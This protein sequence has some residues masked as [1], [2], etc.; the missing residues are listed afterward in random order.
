MN[1]YLEVYNIVLQY[2]ME[3]IH[4]GYTKIPLPQTTDEFKEQQWLYVAQQLQKNNSKEII[5]IAAEKYPILQQIFNG[6]D[7][8]Q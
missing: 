5:R 7:K 6:E 2:K 4:E 3:F 8:I 1:I